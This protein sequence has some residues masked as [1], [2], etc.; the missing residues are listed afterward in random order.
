MLKLECQNLIFF[1]FSFVSKIVYKDISGFGACFKKYNIKIFLSCYR[2]KGIVDC[3]RI[4]QN[5][6]IDEQ[7]LYH[8]FFIVKSN[9]QKF[10]FLLSK[11]SF[12][13]FYT[14]L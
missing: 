13:L 6:I 8:Q 3:I 4:I 1:C 10:T 12:C 5:C 9:L 11:N 14:L 7:G 2:L